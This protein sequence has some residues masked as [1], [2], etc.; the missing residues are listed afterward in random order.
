MH[1]LQHE[2]EQAGHVCELSDLQKEFSRILGY[3]GV[4]DSTLS[5]CQ[6]MSYNLYKITPI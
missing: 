6:G 4:K 2:V 3:Q 5:A 1:L